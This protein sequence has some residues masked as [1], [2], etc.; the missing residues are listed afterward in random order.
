MNKD[1]IIEMV[2]QVGCK[3]YSPPPTR[4]VAGVSMTF[5]QVEAL[6]KLSE[7][8]EREACARVAEN[9]FI[10]TKDVIEE[11]G[12]QIATSIRARGEA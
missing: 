10:G 4:S 6:I 2:N 11:C 5:A 7:K 3:S 1:E 8:R 9:K 12:F